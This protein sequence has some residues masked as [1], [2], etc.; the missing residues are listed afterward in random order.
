MPRISAVPPSRALPSSSSGADAMAATVAAFCLIADGSVELAWSM[1]AISPIRLL[2]IIWRSVLL[3]C[4]AWEGSDCGSLIVDATASAIPVPPLT[5]PSAA[6][7]LAS[8]SGENR[9]PR[10]KQP[11][12]RALPQPEQW[13]G[14]YL[15]LHR[16]W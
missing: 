3:V 1:L 9:L 8:V 10:E 11:A 4:G 6:F 7:R 13:T 5:S 16:R 15:Q 12:H 14:V 2:R